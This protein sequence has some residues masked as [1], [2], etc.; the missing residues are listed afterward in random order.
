MKI[1]KSILGIIIF[2]IILVFVMLKLGDF[3][4]PEWNDEWLNTSTV[5]NFYD[6]DK[7]SIDVFAVG[8][9]HIIKGFS[10]LELY[11]NYGISAYGLGTEQQS[12]M[13]SYAWVKESLK[14]QNEKVVLLE[15]H[16]LFEET[17]E[18]QNRKGMDNM[19]LS[20]NKIECAYYDSIQRNSFENFASLIFPVLR[21]HSRW[22]EVLAG[23]NENTVQPVNYR[24][25]SLSN[26]VCGNQDYVTLDESVTSEREFFWDYEKLLVKFI[27]YCKNNNLNLIIYKSPDM[28]WDMERYN[29]VKRVADAND[30][31]YIDFNLE[32]LSKE[33][34]FLYAA[35]C[36][37]LNHL[38]IYGAQKVTNYLGKYIKEHYD[39]LDRRN[40]PNYDYLDEQL[41]Q[42]EY[43]VEN[44]KLVNIFEPAQYIEALKS[45][46]FTVVYVKNNLIN[47][48]SANFS[49]MI[50][51][52]GFDINKVN[53]PNYYAI[54]EGG[55][56]IAEEGSDAPLKIDT[57]IDDGK[58][59]KIN[60]EEASIFFQGSERSNK[61]QGFDI[62]IYN[63]KTDNVVES[64]Y[65]NFENGI[66]TMGR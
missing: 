13:N 27:N 60:T 8:S 17:P 18:P 45:N 4:I 21:F 19:K 24:G 22:N 58:N 23:E 10:S 41:E 33:I 37:L 55:K 63:N 28:D 54:V 52:L 38:N 14:T 57:K 64:G 43:A 20:F 49:Q 1:L 25:Y 2:L 11:K 9:S 16:M 32:S 59:L 36:E 3:V 6:L 48:G 61:H 15:A 35:D 39:I 47:D 5:K 12:L 34:D 31:P 26:E 53:K 44:A 29:A 30:I 42:Y 56:I 66:T 40:D 7:N 51:E 65:I 50:D 62:M 46:N